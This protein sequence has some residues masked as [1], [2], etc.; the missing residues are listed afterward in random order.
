MKSGPHT[1]CSRHEDR[2][3]FE[4]RRGIVSSNKEKSGRDFESQKALDPTPDAFPA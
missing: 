1:V 4:G 2:T 3:P